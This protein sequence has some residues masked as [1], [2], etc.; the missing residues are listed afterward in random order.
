M[1]KIVCKAEAE[2]QACSNNSP[3]LS[4]SVTAK[5]QMTYGKSE[6]HLKAA[7]DIS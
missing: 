6:V 1:V 7:T 5:S 4:D 2:K 3:F